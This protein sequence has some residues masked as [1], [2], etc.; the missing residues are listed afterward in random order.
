M[1]KQC[2]RYILDVILGKRRG[3]VPKM[4]THGLKFLSFGYQ[5]AVKTRNW[6]FNKGLIACYYPPV[7]V[8]VSVGNIVAGGTGKTPVTLMLAESLIENHKIALLLRGY[9][10]PSELRRTPLVLSKGKGPE[11]SA[12]QSG[13]EP[14]LLSRRLPK[15][16]VYVGKKRVQSSIMAAKSGAEVI[17]LD[18]GMQHRRLAREFEIVV[19][20]ASDP[21]G[22]GHFLPR[23]FL[24]DHPDALK[25]ADL[26]VVNHIT[27][28]RQLADVAGKLKT[29]SQAPMVGVCPQ[30]S[31]IESISGQGVPSLSGKKAGLFCGIAKPENF[32]TLVE[33]QGV[34]VVS[35]LICLDH[36]L[37]GKKKLKKFSEEC[38]KRG[39]EYLICT[40]KD[41]VKLPE[42][43]ETALPICS[44]N[45]RLKIVDGAEHWENILDKIKMKVGAK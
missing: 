23:G 8:V 33:S 35:E 42:D 9:R 10:S 4:T 25:R 24:R 14:Y 32:K 1:K 5:A 11:F 27:S 3:F 26:I 12:S 19:L 13:D 17:I 43:I 2:E 41:L 20:D 34:S 15:A 16:L 21:L 40:E 29:Y 6:A 44:V 31:S 45:M 36:T 30:I 7:P 38:A 28:C 18:D 22:E 39:A 37:P